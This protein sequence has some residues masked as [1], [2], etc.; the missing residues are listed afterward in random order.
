MDQAF[1]VSIFKEGLDKSW[2][3]YEYCA[4]DVEATGLDLRRDEVIS[5][6][7][8]TI[9]DGRFKGVGNFYEEIAPS[10]SP[11]HSSVQIHGLRGI[12]LEKAKHADEVF[13]Q[14]IT[15][16]SNKRLIAHASWV[17]KAFLSTLLK[18]H[19]YSFPKKVVDTASLARFIGLAEKESGHEPAL[20]FLARSLNLPVYTPHHALGDAM[21]TAAVFLALATRIENELMEKSGEILSLEKLLNISKK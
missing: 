1:K 4:V 17:E 10:R 11:S 19:G 20:E 2:R 6:G 21:T 3:A 14:L 16:L 15:Y 18:R 5:I 7:A 12:D 9:A 8:V 13:P